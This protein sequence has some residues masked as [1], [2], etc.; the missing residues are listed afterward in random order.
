MSL[1]FI[2]H[3]YPFAVFDVKSTY[4]IKTMQ[5]SSDGY[6]DAEAKT[7]IWIYQAKLNL[8]DEVRVR[9]KAKKWFTLVRVEKT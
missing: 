8:N 9:Q 7:E 6:G 4:S 3:I 2:A 1:S 5:E